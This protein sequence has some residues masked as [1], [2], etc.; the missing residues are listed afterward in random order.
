LKD[1]NLQTKKD[2]VSFSKTRSSER[3]NELPCPLRL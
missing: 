3:R 1:K 2:M